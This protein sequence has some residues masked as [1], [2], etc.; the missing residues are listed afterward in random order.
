[1]LFPLFVNSIKQ[2][3]VYE[4]FAV[5]YNDFVLPFMVGIIFA[6]SYLLIGLVKIVASLPLSD[7]KK[8]FLALVNPKK[9]F[10]SIKDI[11]LDC[12]IHVK[13]FKKKPI[14]GY[15]HAS[16]AFGW[17]MLIVIGHIEVWLYTPQRMGLL[18][19]PIFFRYFV[20]EAAHTLRGSFFFFLMD[21]FLLMVLSGIVLALIKRVR[22]RILGMRRTTKTSL[23]DKIAMY[24]LWAIFPLRLLAESFSAGISGG[25]F[26]TKPMYWL[27]NNFL[28]N[29][30][31]ILPTW[32]AYSIALGA[33]FVMLPF[34]RYMHI[35]TEIVLIFMRHA[36]IKTTHYRKGFAETEIYSC[37]SCGICLDPC[38]MTTQRKNL[39]YTSVYYMRFLRRRNRKKSKEIADKCLMCGKCVANCPV[40]I[41]SCA[42]KQAFRATE[43]LT[44]TPD[45]KYLETSPRLSEDIKILYYAGCMTKLTPSIIKSIS[46]ILDRSGL[47]WSYMDKEEG[48]CCGRPQ[49]LAGNNAAA[50]ALIQKNK[51]IIEQS[52]AT[53][54]LLTC[55]ICYKIFTESYELKNIRIVHHSVFIKELI[56]NGTLKLSGDETKYV[57]H[58]PC[59]LGRGTGIYKEPRCV[60]NNIGT[61]VKAHEELKNSICCGASLGSMTLSYQ[62]RLHVTDLSLRSLSIN[63]PDTIVTSCPLCLK[64]FKPASRI[65]VADIAEIVAEKIIN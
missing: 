30:Y 35:P 45:Y 51:E 39:K 60:L 26:L 8:F 55:P 16:I 20:A 53:T 62:D 63:N 52:G 19:Y 56:E 43:Q 65:R 21:F 40:G 2:T 14:L 54:L 46:G 28:T 48:I 57:Y 49:F 23:P 25:S 18:Y 29:D 32:W 17:F 22:S 9:M 5:P 47:E 31:H 15:M 37:S 61:L 6:L 4:R 58:D 1:M 10:L 64:T 36:G 50:E 13:I 44:V 11:I 27:F 41:E 12:L 24:S 3:E 33:F 38:P 7:R 34:S 59:E 42:L